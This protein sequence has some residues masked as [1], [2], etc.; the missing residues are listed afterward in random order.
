MLSLLWIHDI[1]F[2]LAGQIKGEAIVSVEERAI[3][4]LKIEIIG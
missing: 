2:T 1:K 4:K 3:P